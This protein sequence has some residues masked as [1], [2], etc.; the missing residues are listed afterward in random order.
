MNQVLAITGITG[1]SG[2]YLLQELVKHHYSGEV[3]CLIRESSNTEHLDSS[4]LNI[5]KIY[6]DISDVRVLR[7]LLDGADIVIN[8]VNL[9]YTLPILQIA[10]ELHVR[11]AIAVHTTGIY[12]KYKMAAEEYKNIEKN[13]ACFMEQSDIDLTILRPTMIFGDMCDHNISKF[14]RIVDMLPVIPVINGGDSKIQPVNARDLGYAY[15]NACIRA[16]L[17]EDEYIVSGEK[18]VTMKELFQW[19]AS[20]LGKKRVFVNIPLSIGVAVAQ[21]VK[22]ISFG[23]IDYVERV[24][25]MAENR[26]YPHSQASKDIDYMPE[27]FEIGL[28]R[29]VF[30]YQKLKNHRM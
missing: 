13:I 16:H 23:R 19:I 30:E 28:E 14:I 29:E 10:E 20:F 24:L 4:R 21:L 27:K 22:Y 15:Y 6:G 3:R 18:P 17:P 26:D 8:I 11:R 12:S 25:R 2:R 1:H 5:R 7:T 9:R